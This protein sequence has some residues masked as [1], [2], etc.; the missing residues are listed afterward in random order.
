[1]EAVWEGSI[2]V[3]PLGAVEQH[4]PH[5]PLDTDT[6][7]ATAVASQA[8][9][10]ANRPDL[11]LLPTLPYGASGEHAGFPGTISIGTEALATVLIEIA[12]SVIPPLRGLVIVSGHGG[13]SHALQIAAAALEIE[14]RPFHIWTPSEPPSDL[15]AG[16]HETSLLLHLSPDAVRQDQITDGPSQDSPSF[17]ADL[18][19]HGVKGHSP[20]G[21][22]GTPSR[23]HAEDGAA[24][25][26]RYVRQ[27]ADYLLQLSP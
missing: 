23:A 20:S 12:R 3:L 18:Q 15:H 2:G 10:D 25:F 8:V 5:L 14:Q 19:E 22:L 16:H 17:I 27:L 6:V 11:L 26:S 24:I 13:N 21:V 7:I 1:M 4:G 9:K